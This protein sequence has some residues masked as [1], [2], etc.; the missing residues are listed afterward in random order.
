MNLVRAIWRRRGAYL[1]IAAP[2]LSLLVFV[3]Y[4]LASSLILSF[5][6]WNGVQPPQWIG[7]A[8]YYRLGRDEEF[9]ISVRN[10][11]VFAVES[12]VGGVGIALVAALIIN[13]R[14][15]GHNFFRAV[16]FLPVVTNMVAIGFL[17]KLIYH[18]RGLL[19]YLISLVGFDPIR[20]LGH[21][22]FA[23]HSIVLMSIWQGFGYSMVLFLAALQ[24]IPIELYEAATIDGANVWHR[25]RHVTWPGLQNIMLFISITGVSGAFTVFTQ[26]YVMTNGGPLS[27]TQ[28]IM[29]HLF[30]QFQ[31]LNLGYANAIGFSL[32]IF[33]FVFALINLKLNVHE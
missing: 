16:Y 6:D 32:F 33:L 4:P 28:T 22:D 15:R 20:W 11:V 9:L 18:P 23:L 12:L 25:F 29:L 19:N 7:L 14:L 17:W 3:A 5:T 27:S 10:T 24:T 8:N 2:L 31:S 30:N 21:P 1:F 13:R 26:I